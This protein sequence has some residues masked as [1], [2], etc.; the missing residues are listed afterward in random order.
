MKS[1]V[2]NLENELETIIYFGFVKHNVNPPR[3]SSV[4]GIICCLYVP[5]SYMLDFDYPTT[6]G[7][8][9]LQCLLF[10]DK[11]APMNVAIKFKPYYSNTININMKIL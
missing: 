11:Q 10:G 7:L 4:K 6:L 5:V 8:L 1:S 2:H 3:S 9:M